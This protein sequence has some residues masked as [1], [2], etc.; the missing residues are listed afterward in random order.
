LVFPH[1]SAIFSWRRGARGRQGLVEARRSRAPTT[2]SEADTLACLERLFE[3]AVRGTCTGAITRTT[4]PC[5][6]RA[7][8]PACNREWELPMGGRGPT[9]RSLAARRRGHRRRRERQAPS[10]SRRRHAQQDVS[11]TSSRARSSPRV[12][13]RKG[14]LVLV[15]AP[16]HVR[17]RLVLLLG[18]DTVASTEPVGEPSFSIPV[19]VPAGRSA[20]SA[21]LKAGRAAPPYRFD[22]A[23]RP[24]PRACRC[25]RTRGSSSCAP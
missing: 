4:T 19:R 6:A 7:R 24:A 16:V 9:R 8:G 18:P 15:I 3:H 1:R 22:R 13:A 2:S 17:G 23:A 14:V 12:R 10:L 5:R 20:V 21:R 11:L 25:P